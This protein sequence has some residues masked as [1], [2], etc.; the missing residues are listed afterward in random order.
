MHQKEGIKILHHVL[1]INIFYLTYYG[2]KRLYAY[3]EKI[4]DYLFLKS[5]IYHYFHY[6]IQC[7]ILRIEITGIR[8]EF[9][10]NST[11]FTGIPAIFLR[12]LVRIFFILN[13]F[14]LLLRPEKKI[15]LTEISEKYG[16]NSYESGKILIW[17]V[18]TCR[19]QE[20][21]L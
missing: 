20:K 1:H 10:G 18:K 15:I 16:R 14:K 7:R 9:H 6:R 8:A 11:N 17:R 21:L 3:I 19:F 2:F 12:Y 5:Q 13:H 4:V